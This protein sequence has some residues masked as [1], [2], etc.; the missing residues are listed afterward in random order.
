MAMS[1]LLENFVGQDQALALLRS[2]VTHPLHAYVLYG[3]TGCGVVPASREF[4]AALVCEQGGCGECLHCVK[5]LRGIHPDVIVAMAEG[6]TYGVEYIRESL[7]VW[8][9]RR[10]LEAKRTVIVVPEADAITAPVAGAFLK[11]IEEPVA[12]TVFVLLATSLPRQ[13]IT[14]WSRCAEVAFRSLS[15]D[16]VAS[17]LERDGIEA[18]QARV[19]AQGAVGDVSRAKLFANDPGFAERLAWWRELPNRLDGSGATAVELVAEIEAALAS[20]VEP[21]RLAQG[22]EIEELEEQARALGERGLPGREGI[23]SRHRREVRRVQARELD[24]GLGALAGV[25]RD[26]MHEA[27]AYGSETANDAMRRAAVA[28]DAIS[29]LRKSL[30][31]NPRQTLALERLLLQLS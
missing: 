13:H 18:T 11:M 12:T 23:T 30:V 5:A 3:P 10:P 8:A 2:A 4:A 27:V 15:V 1:Q 9:Q 22:E 28:S 29:R 14:I 26:R 31:R 24:A 25:Y 20:V 19:L 21:L 16:D 7:G 17:I 6:V